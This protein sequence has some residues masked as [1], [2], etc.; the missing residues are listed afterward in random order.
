MTKKERSTQRIGIFGGSFDPVHNGHL[1]AA[2]AVINAVQLDELRLIPAAL[3]P[4]KDQLH[5]TPVQRLE[6]LQLAIADM[7]RVSIDEIELN[8]PPPSYTVDTLSTLKQ[9]FPQAVQ[10]FLILGQDAWYGF[11]KWHHWQHI[12]DLAHLVVVN[13]PGSPKQPPSRFWLDRLHSDGNPTSNAGKVIQINMPPHTA[14]STEIR[15]RIRK[16][17]DLRP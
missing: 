12:L 1:A 15:Q 10:L 5:A 3:S 7:P 17:Q 16:H 8:R 13:R 11:E 4:F 6:M 14:S 9:A 2:T